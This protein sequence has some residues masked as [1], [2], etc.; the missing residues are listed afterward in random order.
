MEDILNQIIGYFFV[1]LFFFQTFC[2]GAG[3]V[4]FVAVAIWA[5][6]DLKGFKSIEGDIRRGIKISNKLLPEEQREYL[7]G[8]S[9]D[10]VEYGETLFG[11]DI[12]AFIRKKNRDVIIYAR[13]SYGFR[14]RRSWP[15]VGYV[16][17]SNVNP[18]LEFR[19]SLPFV[20]FL[21]LLALS[22]FLLPFVIG[23][24]FIGFSM[25]I[26]TIENLLQSKTKS[27]IS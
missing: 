11:K 18:V 5:I 25:E 12:S 10:V 16:N 20:L 8:L 24:G 27:A 4:T 17:L 7:E 15:L 6:I 13:Q 26:Q 9:E 1:L 2:G 14:W 21:V 22:I 3:G 23:L 19:S